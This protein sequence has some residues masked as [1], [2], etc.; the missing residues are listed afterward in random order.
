[1]VQVNIDLNAVETMDD[2]SQMPKGDYPAVI[3]ANEKNEN[4]KGTGSYLKIT[5]QIIEGK[6]KN[7]TQWDFLNL[8][9]NSLETVEIAT[10]RLATIAQAVGFTEQLQ[11]VDQLMQ[12]PALISIALDVNRNGDPSNKV[13]YYKSITQMQTAATQ[14]API[15]PP[16]QQAPAYAPPAPPAAAIAA[17]VYT[18]PAAAPLPQTGQL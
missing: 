4:S 12:Q 7:R 3:I 2:F 10:K 1:M 17:P 13:T 18:P 8:W 6:Y 15:D 16:I 14:S 11:D 5:W 9:H